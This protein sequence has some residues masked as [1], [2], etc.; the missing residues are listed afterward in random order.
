MAPKGSN[1]A[2]GLRARGAIDPVPSPETCGDSRSRKEVKSTCSCSILR[3]LP[4]LFCLI[5]T[6][7]AVYYFNFVYLDPYTPS[8]DSTTS[9]KATVPGEIPKVAPSPKLETAT[10]N[11]PKTVVPP[12]D[13]LKMP[14][15]A[16]QFDIVK[17]GNADGPSI[18]KGQSV[19]VHALGSVLNADGSK[20]KFWSTKDAGQQ[21]FTWN[22]GIG[23]VIAGWDQG[24]LGMKQGEIRSINIPASMGYG[25][26]GFPAWGIPAN[27][28]LHFEIECLK[29]N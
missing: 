17:P 21:P 12:K 16:L 15:T 11:Q 20:K 23:Q 26:S 24:V 13:K 19:T 25:A 27:A 9:T 8:L 3:V 14:L 5:F 18:S 6:G 29:L 4:I 7:F 10:Q 2:Q 1:D 28:D 22:A